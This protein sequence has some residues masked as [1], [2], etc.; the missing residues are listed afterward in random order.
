MF[1]KQAEAVACYKS[2]EALRNQYSVQRCCPA[3]KP[4]ATSTIRPMIIDVLVFWVTVVSSCIKVASVA[5]SALAVPDK[6]A[7]SRPVMKA[8]KL[9]DSRYITEQLG[10]VYWLRDYCGC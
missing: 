3:M 6:K 1:I 4:R 9:M 5:G 7:I 2:E 10:A 8:S